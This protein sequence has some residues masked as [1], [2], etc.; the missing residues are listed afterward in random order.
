MQRIVDSW[1]DLE[2]PKWKHFLKNGY[3]QA[4]WVFDFTVQKTRSFIL[5]VFLILPKDPCACKPSF[6]SNYKLLLIR[7]HFHSLCMVYNRLVD[8]LHLNCST[9]FP[10]RIHKLRKRLYAQQ[11]NLADWKTILANLQSVALFAFPRLDRPSGKRYHKRT[12]TE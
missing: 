3:E 4:E 6:R 12:H 11:I 2:G 9:S 7:Y 5:P 1:I 10:Y 8:L